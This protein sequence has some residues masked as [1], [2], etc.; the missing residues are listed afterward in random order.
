MCI[1]QGVGP[2]V[3]RGVGGG[4]GGSEA[5]LAADWKR[6]CRGRSPPPGRAGGRPATQLPEMTAQVMQT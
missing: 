5:T 3:R 4:A 1:F 2:G 6:G